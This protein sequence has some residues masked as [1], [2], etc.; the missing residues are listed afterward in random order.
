MKLELGIPEEVVAAVVALSG[1][2]RAGKEACE[3]L[4]KN[5]LRAKYVEHQKILVAEKHLAGFVHQANSI[6]FD[7]EDEEQQDG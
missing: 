5:T 6:T 7:A 2:S 4:V 3:N 1:G